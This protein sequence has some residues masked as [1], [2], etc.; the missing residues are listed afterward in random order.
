M[1]QIFNFCK[2]LLKNILSS[3]SFNTTE[4]VLILNIVLKHSMNISISKLVS[5]VVIEK[6]AFFPHYK[7][8][9]LVQLFLG[10]AGTSW[11]ITKSSFK[12]SNN[13]IPSE[14][15]RGPPH[16]QTRIDQF[17]VTE[18][19]T[20]TNLVPKWSLLWIWKNAY[21]NATLYFI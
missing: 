12:Y 17:S 19:D 3:W 18:H 15:S 21:E 13:R 20:V 1:D 2:S 9:F 7:S 5:P 4:K 14:F 6:H 8:A 16:K 10:V 11:Y